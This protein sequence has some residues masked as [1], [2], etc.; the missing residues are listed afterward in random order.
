MPGS[1]D[2]A[3]A[4]TSSAVCQFASA[5]PMRAASNTT[6][7]GT[8]ASSRKRHELIGSVEKRRM[9]RHEHVRA[10]L[11]GFANGRHRRVERAGHA[12]DFAEG[13]PTSRP[14]RSQ[15]S[16]SAGGNMRFRAET[17]SPTNAGACVPLFPQ[18]VHGPH[19]AAPLFLINLVFLFIRH[20][21]PPCLSSRIGYSHLL[22]ARSV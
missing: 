22:N 1:I 2:C 11:R 6:E 17:S 13:S 10:E 20:N 16:A 12:F 8:Q 4:L 19:G 5:T 7:P 15:G 18:E 9:M 21:R 14:V 3:G